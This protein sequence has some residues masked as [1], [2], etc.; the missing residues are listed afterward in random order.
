[1]IFFSSNVVDQKTIQY[2]AVNL[3]DETIVENRPP[4]LGNIN[5]SG[6]NATGQQVMGLARLDPDS[7]KLVTDNVLQWAINDRISLEDA[8]TLPH[9][10]VTVS[11]CSLKKKSC[12]TDALCVARC[13]YM[14]VNFRL[15]CR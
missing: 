4:Q 14:F 13:D 10:Y 15:I 2:V 3:L 11:M 9:A 1:M 8:A 12:A 6:T 5:Y 7:H